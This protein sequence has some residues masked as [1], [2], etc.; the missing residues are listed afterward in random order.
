MLKHG[1]LKPNFKAFMADNAHANWNVIRIIYSYGDPS[2][3]MID[4]EC[5]CIFHWTQSFD[6]N[7]KQLIRPNLQDQHNVLC[8][9]Y[10]N[11]K[12]FMEAN[13]LYVTIRCW[14]FSL[15]ATFEASV[16]ELANWLSF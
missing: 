2:I 6:K 15:G 9:E 14:W 5:T 12:S 13:G 4:K 11:E 16:H 8:H 7:T 1:F 3:R 10:T